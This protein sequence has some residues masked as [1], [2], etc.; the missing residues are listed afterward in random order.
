MFDGQS[1]AKAGLTSSQFGIM[2]RNI[3]R[4]LNFYALLA[5]GIGELCCDQIEFE[6]I[7]AMSSPPSSEVAGEVECSFYFRK[8]KLAKSTSAIDAFNLC[9]SPVFLFS[10]SCQY[11]SLI[12]RSTPTQPNCETS[13]LDQDVSTPNTF[14]KCPTSANGEIGRSSL[15]NPTCR[16]CPAS[17]SRQDE[18]QVVIL[19]YLPS[20][21]L[22]DLVYRV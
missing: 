19:P 2:S 3:R 8:A 22:L 14:D 11:L 17:T 6:D 21:V 9:S 15:F 20:F 13:L 12:Y 18:R 5:Q 16:S 7:I 4:S 1:A 10:S